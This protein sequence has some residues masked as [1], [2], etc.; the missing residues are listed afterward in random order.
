METFKL[1]EAEIDTVELFAGFGIMRDEDLPNTPHDCW[2]RQPTRYRLTKRLL[3][4][5]FWRASSA[6]SPYEKEDAAM[7][8]R[9]LSGA[10]RLQCKCVMSMAASGFAVRFG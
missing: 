1:A 5:V 9:S 10:V 4:Y 6:C 2:V 3:M 8:V 7:R